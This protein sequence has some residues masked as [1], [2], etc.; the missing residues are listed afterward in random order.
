MKGIPTLTGYTSF[1]S[2]PALTKHA[3]T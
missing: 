1:T 3:G 2:Q